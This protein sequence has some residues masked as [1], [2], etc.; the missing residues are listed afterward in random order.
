MRKNKFL[1]IVEQKKNTV[2]MIIDTMIRL[3]KYI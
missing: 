3:K 1:T 2:L